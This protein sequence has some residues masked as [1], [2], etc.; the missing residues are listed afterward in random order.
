MGE[1]PVKY[2]PAMTCWRRL[3]RWQKEGIWKKIWKELLV[4][5]EKEEKI[6]WE[7]TYLDG[8]FSP[9]KKGVQK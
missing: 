8:T 9:A 2:G 1:L 6:E 4:M 3:K 5:L 7:V